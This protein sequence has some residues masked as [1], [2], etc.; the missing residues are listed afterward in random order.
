MQFAER[1]KQ[2][3]IKANL[4]Q[5]ELAQ[6]IG[7]DPAIIGRYETQG[8][9]PRI[10]TCL[11]LAIALSCTV[12]DLAG[13]E[14][15][16][17]D[18][19][20]AAD[21]LQKY[22]I[23]LEYDHESADDDPAVTIQAIGSKT[24]LIFARPGKLS[25]VKAIIKKSEDEADAFVRDDRAVSMKTSLQHYLLIEPMVDELAKRMNHDTGDGDIQQLRKDIAY[26][27]FQDLLEKLETMQGGAHT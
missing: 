15:P 24:S 10:D 21:Y 9:L 2:L 25:E 18:A 23:G 19:H 6:K 4:S 14:P 12:D 7:V 3:R 13:Y 1:L 17:H 5:K 8:T 26:E 20:W 16:E 11:K 22:G 27:Y